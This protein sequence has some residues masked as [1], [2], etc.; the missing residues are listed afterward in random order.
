MKNWLESLRVLP[1]LV[2]AY[3]AIYTL[4]NLLIYNTVGGPEPELTSFYWVRHAYYFGKRHQMF[5]YLG[6]VLALF[7]II[8]LWFVYE[9]LD[10]SFAK[11]RKSL[12]LD[13]V[14]TFSTVPIF[15]LLSSFLFWQT[16]HERQPIVR[17]YPMLAMFIGPL[18][19]ATL[20]ML[21]INYMR[22]K[23]QLDAQIKQSAGALLNLVVSGRSGAIIA[24]LSLSIFGYAY[25]SIYRPL[26]NGNLPF[27]NEYLNVSSKLLVDG[28]VVDT[29]PAL[30]SIQQLGIKIETHESFDSIIERPILKNAPPQVMWDLAKANPFVLHFDTF[31]NGLLAVAPISETLA[32]K[33]LD[34]K[35]ANQEELDQ[36]LEASSAREHK[37]GMSLTKEEQTFL[38]AFFPNLVQQVYSRWYIHHH[39]FVSGPINKVDLGYDWK[40]VFFQYGVIGGLV[41]NTFSKWLFGEFSFESYFKVWILFFMAY[42]GIF[43]I[44]VFLI[45]RDWQILLF[46]VA[47][48][49]AF[50]LSQTYE[51]IFLGPGLNPLRHFLDILVFWSLFE[52][53]KRK[54]FTWLILTS[55]LTFLNFCLNPEF[56]TFCYVGFLFGLSIFFATSK[57]LPTPKEATVL[58]LFAVL[59]LVGWKLLRVGT[60]GVVSLYL[61]GF[62]SPTV[63]H[64]KILMCFL[65]LFI[66]MMALFS[67]R[68]L[69]DRAK[70]ALF[71]GAVLYS[72]LILS[73][74]L[75]GRT[76]NHLVNI[77]SILIFTAIFGMN[78]A[79]DLPFIKKNLN[80]LKIAGLAAVFLL[81]LVCLD[82]FKRGKSEYYALLERFENQKWS[83]PGG[84]IKTSMPEEPFKSSVELISKYQKGNRIVLFSKF[85]NILYLL[86]R[87]YSP[88]PANEVMAF[89]M[90]PAE[91]NLLKEY[92]FKESPDY[93]L[94][95][96]DISS[97]ISDEL[98]DPNTPMVGG[99]FVESMMRLE[100]VNNLKILFHEIFNDYEP[101]EAA[102]FLT[103][104][105]KKGKASRKSEKQIALYQN[106]RE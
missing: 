26:Y 33:I 48:F 63:P 76:W 46:S 106:I 47:L 31:Q 56:G 38:A 73:Y 29:I 105:K 17:A 79:V 102:G 24:V 27:L 54:A 18:V 50:V 72:I 88:L 87:T 51:H 85:D 77:S 25:F 15:A 10:P 96:Q 62:F 22:K 70:L 1:L 78:A 103:V 23:K 61:G 69:L 65:V 64:P 95:D 2:A 53:F 40:K 5:S 34:L 60:E 82:H 41:Q 101:V 80:F 19:C 57:R 52:F 93:I 8:F 16:F 20:V 7:G 12:D 100:R 91:K 90:S 42:F 30:N 84:R 67:V 43:I 45:T 92:F 39:N 94:A 3:L 11:L 75:W 99:L 44:G 9:I 37:K 35:I 32:Q 68:H 6:N 55:T 58:G 28:K 21:N 74:C 13:Q 4:C 104:W 89:M 83:I 59:H 81:N 49:V 66:G 97:P 36:F 14:G 98:I 71:M 86:S